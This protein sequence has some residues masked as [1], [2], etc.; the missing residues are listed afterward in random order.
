MTPRENPTINSGLC[1]T[2]MG[3]YRFSR[4]NKC[5]SLVEDSD[6]GKGYAWVQAG[7]IWEVSI[8]SIQFCCESKIAL[9]TK[10]YKKLI[11]KLFTILE[12][13]CYHVNLSDTCFET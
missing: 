13:F 3:Q 6:E 1:V 9:K 7:G 8:H 2:M 4:Y 10:V 11:T 5:T 12:E